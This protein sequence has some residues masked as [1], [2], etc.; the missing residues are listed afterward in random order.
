MKKLLV[1]GIIILFI[2][3]SFTSCV[4]VNVKQSSSPLNTGEL[5]WWKFDVGHGTIAYDSSGHGYDGTVVGATWTADGLTFDGM[6]DYVDFDAHSTALGMNKTDDYIVKVRFRSTGSGMLY[7][8]SHTNPERPY[9]NLMMDGEGKVGVIM[10]DITCTFDLFTTGSYNDGEWHLVESDFE[11]DATNPTLNLFIDSELEATTTE[12]L[13]PMI[14]EDFNTAKVGRDSNEESD[15]LDGEIDDIKIYKNYRPVNHPPDPPF[16]NGPPDG[17]PGQSLTFEFSAIDPDDDDVRFHIDWDDGIAETTFYVASG[18]YAIVDHVWSKGG[19]YTISAIAE[20]EY[21]AFSNETFFTF[22]V[23]KSKAVNVED[24]D[25]QTVV[26]DADLI[27]LESLLNRVEKRAKLLLVLS[28]N[29]PDIK[30]NYDKLADMISQLNTLG[31]K[32]I[33]IWLDGMIIDFIFNTAPYYL[34]L[35]VEY[36]MENRFIS[37]FLTLFPVIMYTA[38]GASIWTI[39]IFINCGDILN[40]HAFQNRDILLNKT[41]LMGHHR[42]IQNLIQIR[43]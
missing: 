15:F 30:E 36:Y 11:G 8:M 32:E 40:T 26:S 31:L 22:R 2:G 4:G 5:A 37:A 34:G 38:L 20:D 28:K 29:N 43:N 35:A 10:G 42:M 13:C 39:Y 3:V 23:G 18:A 17:E 33:C 27:K 21:G 1:V 41:P 24:C 19:V 16:I 12:W 14:D 6:G 25:C 9:Y 7:S